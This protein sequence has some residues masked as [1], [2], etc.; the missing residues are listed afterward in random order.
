MISSVSDPLQRILLTTI[1]L[2]VLLH[3]ISLYSLPTM[4]PEEV[5]SVE[6]AEDVDHQDFQLKSYDAL[7]PTFQ[8]TAPLALY[9]LTEV[10]LLS[11]EQYQEAPFQIS[12]ED[13]YLEI[14]F[15]LIIGPNAP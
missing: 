7:I 10:Q 4:D 13:R 11:E 15:P 3:S 14:L 8:G 12:Y 2:V 1:S 5:S 9:F 6:M